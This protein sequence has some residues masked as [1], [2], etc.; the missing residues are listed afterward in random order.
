[1]ANGPSV[2]TI[3]LTTSSIPLYLPAEAR[4]WRR[5]LTSSKGT[6][7]KASVAPAVAP[8]RMARGWFIFSIPKAER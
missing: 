3:F 5:I 6:T 7:T 2:L 8:V 1:M 4:S